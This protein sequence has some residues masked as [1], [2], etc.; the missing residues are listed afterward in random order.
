MGPRGPCRK[1]PPLGE[2]GDAV[3]HMTHISYV[4]HGRAFVEEQEHEGRGGSHRESASRASCASLRHSPVAELEALALTVRRLSPDRR[5]PERFHA[6]K[7][8]VAAALR[9][10]AR[11][12][13]AA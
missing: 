8:E 2:G 6:E 5:D 13:R 12:W 4:G 7:S 9:R 1:S 3:T 10:L 11:E